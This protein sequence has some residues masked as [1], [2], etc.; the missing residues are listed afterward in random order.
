MFF[1]EK[2]QGF[3]AHA[4]PRLSF[5]YRRANSTSPVPALSVC[6]LMLKWIVSQMAFSIFSESGT[7]P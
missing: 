2:P 6:G 5:F 4:G 1:L 3:A 7:P